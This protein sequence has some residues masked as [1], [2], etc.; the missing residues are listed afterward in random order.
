M[1]RILSCALAACALTACAS[2]GRANLEPLVTDRPDFTESSDVVPAGMMQLE[3]GATISRVGDERGTTVGEALVRAGLSSRAELRVGLNSY[4][5]VTSPA[6]RQQGLEDLSLG[7]KIGLIPGGGLVPKVS[8]IVATSLP[9]GAAPFRQSMLQPEAKLTAA[10]DLSDRVAFSSNLNYSR[11]REEAGSYGEA[12]A[13]ASFGFG[14]TER[15]GLYTEYFGFFPRDGFTPASH[16][17]NGGF[18]WVLNP[19]LQLDIRG[20]IG[21]N[22]L[23]RRDYFSGLGLSRRW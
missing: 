3:S 22:G 8:L 6:V 12:A 11:I 1:N 16:Y 21:H 9:T 23:G 10:W 5:V 20:G 17:S 14:L 4:A 15:V 18:T 2:A 19:N 7:A 13:T